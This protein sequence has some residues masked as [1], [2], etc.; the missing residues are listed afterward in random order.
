MS[1]SLT[2]D[3]RARTCQLCQVLAASF[4]LSPL[5]VVVTYNAAC[6]EIPY[7][8][9]PASGRVRPI[10][11]FRSACFNPS[12]PAHQLVN[13]LVYTRT[14]A[15]THTH[16]DARAHTHR[17]TDTHSLTLRVLPE[18]KSPLRTAISREDALQREHSPPAITAERHIWITHTAPAHGTPAAWQ[19]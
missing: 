15:H 3:A 1:L 11:A 5:F 10:R 4:S 2:V 8:V 17:E 9:L 12:K 7:H 14:H 13:A 6:D 19:T 18:I 16:T